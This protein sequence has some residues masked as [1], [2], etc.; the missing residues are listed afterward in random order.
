MGTTVAFAA[1]RGYYILGHLSGPTGRNAHLMYSAA[2]YWLCGQSALLV[3][4]LIAVIL[5]ATSN[6]GANVDM[7]IIMTVMGCCMLPLSWMATWLF[8]AGYV[9][10]SGELYCPPNLTLHGVIWVIFSFVGTFLG[11]GVGG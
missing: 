9:R 4:G 5:S 6:W 1:R 11:T 7:H 8:W 2:L 3:L 10:L